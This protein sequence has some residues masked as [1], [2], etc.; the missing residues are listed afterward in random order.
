MSETRVI[1]KYPNRRLYDTKISSYITLN[2]IKDLVMSYSDFQV[3][4]AKTGDDLTRC[5]LMQIISEEE[6]NGQ[7]LLTSEILKEFVRFYGDSMQA[8]MSRFLE[9]SIKHFMQRRAGLKSPLNTILGANPVSLMQSIAEQNM[10][11]W[12]KSSSS[13][14]KS[15]L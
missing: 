15:A 9:H 2:D 11:S 8:M 3:I 13:K 10:D 5:T 4:D 12:S 6:T 1:K 14:S 7:P